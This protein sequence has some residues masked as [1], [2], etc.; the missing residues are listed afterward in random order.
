MSSGSIKAAQA[1]V[2]I[3]ADQSKFVSKLSELEAK[4]RQFAGRMKEVGLPMLYGGIAALAPIYKSTQHFAKLDDVLRGVKA[5]SGATADEFHRL[6]EQARY[7]GR[8]TS[9][10]S[11]QVAEAMQNLGRAGFNPVQIQTMIPSVMNL[12]RATATPVDIATEIAGNTLRQFNM[13][14]REINRVVDVLTAAANTSAMTVVDLAHSFKY[15]APV[16]HDFGINIEDTAKIIGTLANL[17]LKGEMAGTATRNIL[18]RMGTPTIKAKYEALGV[19][20]EDS[21]T[22]QARKLGDILADVRK[23]LDARNLG[24]VD[25]MGVYHELFGLRS[26]AGGAKLVGSA[27]EDMER[28]IDNA[29]GTAARQAAEMDAGIG[30]TLRI[31]ISAVQG[32]AEAIGEA[33]TPSVIELGAWLTKVINEMTDWVRVNQYSVVWYAK[34]AAGLTAVGAA[35]TAIGTVAGVLTGIVGSVAVIATFP[36]IAGIIAGVTGAV[37]GLTAAVVACNGQIV[38]MDTSAQSATKSLQKMQEDDRTSLQRLETMARMQHKSN[39]EIT[40]MTDIIDTLNGRYESLKLSVDKVTGSVDGL[41]DAHKRLNE[42]QANN[43]INQYENEILQHQ[44]NI[45]KLKPEIKKLEDESKYRSYDTWDLSGKIPR[46]IKRSHVSHLVDRVL[47]TDES[48]ADTDKAFQGLNSVNYKAGPGMPASPRGIL[49]EFDDHNLWRHIRDKSKDFDIRKIADRFKWSELYKWDDYTGS[50]GKTYRRRVDYSETFKKWLLEQGVEVPEFKQN[51]YGS[52]IEQYYKEIKAINEARGKQS[53]VRTYG[54]AE[55]KTAAAGP[56]ARK[57]PELFSKPKETFGTLE[58]Y[59]GSLI[60]KTPT[61]SNTMADRPEHTDDFG[62]SERLPSEGTVTAPAANDGTIKDISRSGIDFINK[63][64]NERIGQL[65]KETQDSSE[66][67]DTLTYDAAKFTHILG[68][69][70]GYTSDN[71]IQGRTPDDSSLRYRNQNFDGS[72]FDNAIEQSIVDLTAMGDRSV[73]NG[74]FARKQLADNL[75]KDTESFAKEWKE[76][77]KS[78][79]DLRELLTK[80]WRLF[81]E[82]NLNSMKT[83][84]KTSSG[85]TERDFKDKLERRF[86][87]H[88]DAAGVYYTMRDE[89]GTTVMENGQVKT[90]PYESMVAEI[91]KQVAEFRAATEKSNRD[92]NAVLQAINTS[93]TLTST[94]EQ[95]KFFNDVFQIQQ[96]AKLNTTLD[97]SKTQQQK[98]IEGFQK[99]KDE[100]DTAVR[101]VY[102]SKKENG[103]TFVSMTREDMYDAFFTAVNGAFENGEMGKELD[104]LRNSDLT[105]EDTT[106]TIDKI[107]EGLLNK[108]IFAKSDEEKKYLIE[109][110]AILDKYK[111]ALAEFGKNYGKGLGLEEWFKLM[112]LSSAMNFDA[113]KYKEEER[114]ANERKQ[115]EDNA[116]REEEEYRSRLIDPKNELARQFKSIEEEAA[117]RDEAAHKLYEQ[118]RVKGETK[119]KVTQKGLFDSLFPQ[120]DSVYENGEKDKEIKDL[121]EGNLTKE[122]SEKTLKTIKDDLLSRLENAE[123]EESER[124]LQRIIDILERY[125]EVLGLLA[126]SDDGT[127]DLNKWLEVMKRGNKDNAEAL[128]AVAEEASAKK[129]KEAEDDAA[130]DAEDEEKKR[131]KAECDKRK[132]M[133]EIDRELADIDADMSRDN[134][135][136]K[137]MFAVPKTQEQ[138]DTEVDKYREQLYPKYNITETEYAGE[139]VS[140]YANDFGYLDWNKVK[141]NLPKT[142]EDV[143]N[144]KANNVASVTWEELKKRLDELETSAAEGNITWDVYDEKKKQL[145]KDSK[146]LNAEPNYR[147]NDR[148]IGA[149]GKLDENK[150]QQSVQDAL[151]VIRKDEREGKIKYIEYTDRVDTLFRDTGVYKKDV[152][153]RERYKDNTGDIDERKLPE[154]MRIEIEK[155]RNRLEDEVIDDYAL[156]GRQQGQGSPLV[157]ELEAVL[158]MEMKK[159]QEDAISSLVEEF[160]N[161]DG[162]IDESGIPEEIKEQIEKVKKTIRDQFNPLI[163]ASKS[164]TTKRGRNQFEGRIQGGVHFDNLNKLAMDYLHKSTAEFNMKTATAMERDKKRKHEDEKKT[165]TPDEINV[166]RMVYRDAQDRRRKAEENYIAEMEKYYGNALEL[167][168]RK[169]KNAM[170]EDEKTGM[171]QVI[172]ELERVVSGIK[173]YEEGVKKRNEELFSVNTK[174]IEKA[175]SDTYEMADAK[176]QLAEAKASGDPA[177][178]RQAEQRMDNLERQRNLERLEEIKSNVS[179]NKSAMEEAGARLQEAQKNGSEEEIS[180]AQEEFKDAQDAYKKSLEELSNFDYSGIMPSVKEGVEN[181]KRTYSS[182]GSFNG[183]EVSSLGQVDYEKEAFKK[184]NALLG[185]I[186]ANTKQMLGNQSKGWRIV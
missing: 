134:K 81:Y 51:R 75:L 1:Y 124:K 35:L 146:I 123:T 183:A 55:D 23:M 136:V 179:D 170:T 130:K 37:A 74:D 41:T 73:L 17:G 106:K 83:L 151:A 100:R 24:P 154:K 147:V 167:A 101:N 113:K 64:L 165:G 177:A 18:A 50:E 48:L 103:E 143:N 109:I 12:S 152:R 10:T 131:R 16:A 166:A 5:V 70:I 119:I 186:A 139:A 127:L 169:R 104:A 62:D 114:G 128:K 56:I 162:T 77:L 171:D 132:S 149:D 86:D 14:A 87:K 105:G 52:V 3:T 11:K 9:F 156:P 178:I 39:E 36:V 96:K 53:T 15:A 176:Q 107:R 44:S 111:D 25:R 141:E 135:N 93:A 122:D 58:E 27:F 181:V 182:R 102:D 57:D 144:A 45:N 54:I 7:L 99:E 67:I 91:D 43:L 46:K 61:K 19:Q 30:G 117:K 69:A 97:S 175:E 66:T 65:K 85:V 49:R 84:A 118:E 2:E 8:T 184:N 63:E 161:A 42:E 145:L 32:A 129:R 68:N 108:H 173:Q 125:S 79:G 6:S 158:R 94:E 137:R 172:K 60:G 95:K 34:A 98:A 22:G 89:D 80:Y 4:M 47:Y 180:E 90:F 112:K 157:N 40:A 150:L 185:E 78:G 163:E 72:A 116:K 71:A 142:E 21:I 20:L 174:D 148:Y 59:L 115:I 26:M 92:L 126:D 28:A 31:L 110:I 140:E 38:E 168:K 138:A 159:K 133:P 29:M 160:R 76:R 121:R 88:D 153:I 155:L 33:M 164:P 82:L 13:E 120:L